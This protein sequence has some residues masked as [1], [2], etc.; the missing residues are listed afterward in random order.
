[1]TKNITNAMSSTAAS[2]TSAR[3]LQRSF[4]WPR[5][6]NG[7]TLPR[8]R[9]I[10]LAAMA[11]AVSSTFAFAQQTPNDDRC[12]AMD[13][14]RQ[15]ENQQPGD[16]QATPA[17]DSDPSRTLA[18]CGGVL[19]PPSVGD[20]QMEKPAPKVGNTPIIKPGDPKNGQQ[21]SQQ[22]SK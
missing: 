11:V 17:P 1:M 7:W 3:S 14:N 8:C 2:S 21:N 18:D 22:P 5:H 13:T 10:L 6:L 20:S 16:G 12:K 9:G 4:D 19:K 15:T